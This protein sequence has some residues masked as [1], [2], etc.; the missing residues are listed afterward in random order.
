MNAF[1]LLINDHRKVAELFDQ[2]ENDDDP[3]MQEN[4][5]ARIKQELTVHS[6]VEENYFYPLV[7]KYEETEEL[8]IEA[9]E[10]HKEVKD[11][12]EQLE[13]MSSDDDEWKDTIQELR[14]AVEHHV[15]EEENELFPK[16]QELL[17]IEYI[18]L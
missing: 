13:S 11:L 5:F 2:I 8:T 9:I 1:E 15:D 6:E 12:L 18:Q 17:G 14:V 3:A 7:L 16:A 10:E 4:I